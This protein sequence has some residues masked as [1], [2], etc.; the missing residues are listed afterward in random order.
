MISTRM[1]LL[2]LI[3]LAVSGAAA[4]AEDLTSGKL[5]FE[6]IRTEPVF[7]AAPGQWDSQIR[8]RGWIMKDGD[9]WKMWYTGYVPDQEPLMM[10]LGYA[11][12][13][14]GIVWRRYPGNPLIT[15][16]WVED[17]MVVKHGDR[18]LMFAEGAGDQA[19]LLESLDGL[20]W[21]RIG[22]L[23]IR[24]VNGQPIPPGPFGTPVVL[25]ENGTWNL[26]YERRD[27]GIWL[28]RSKDLKVWMNVSDEPVI[29]LGPESRDSLMIAMNQVIKVDGKYLAVL[30]GTGTPQKPRQW[31]TALAE[32]TDL[33]HWKKLDGP[34]RPIE[35][36]K[37]SGLLIPDG[38]SWRL[39]TMHN[40]V[41]VH[42]LLK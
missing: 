10:K 3:C 5:N 24:L 7:V 14:D 8:E 2:Q 18:Y 25:F 41:H 6:P 39:Y 27:A 38:N 28:A 13:S 29:G 35:E 4:H 11:T 32:S 26:F 36:N 16:F 12:S 21:S 22:N 17:M 19:Q 23:D 1:F 30:H 42:L 9:V 31:S 33:I 20:K 40:Q 37:S 15:E 34:L